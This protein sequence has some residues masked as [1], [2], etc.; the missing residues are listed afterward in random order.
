[1]EKNINNYEVGIV[2]TFFW[3]GRGADTDRIVECDRQIV[4]G[5]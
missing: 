4:I 2:T 5:I 3:P 1:M